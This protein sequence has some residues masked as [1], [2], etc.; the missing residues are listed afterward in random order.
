MKIAARKA[1]KKSRKLTISELISPD[2]TVIKINVSISKNS[3]PDLITK[4]AECILERKSF[5]KELSTD[6]FLSLLDPKETLFFIFFLEVAR[7]FLELGRVPAFDTPV[8]KSLSAKDLNKKIYSISVGIKNVEEI[9]LQAFRLAF[10]AALEVCLWCSKSEFNRENSTNIFINISENVIKPLQK[11]ASAGKSTIPILKVAHTIGMPFIHLGLGVYQLGWGSKSR[12]IDRSSCESDSAIGAKLTQNKIYTAN[13]L[14]KAGMPAPVHGV[15][16]TNLDALIIAQKIGFP[17]VLKPTDRDRG[18]GVTTNVTNE[19]E[20]NVAFNYAQKLSESKQVIVERQVPGVCHRLFIA[21]G[22]LL[23]CVKRSPISVRG[24]GIKTVKELVDEEVSAQSQKPLWSRSEVKSIDELALRA[25][26][27]AGLSVNSIPNK[28]MIVPLRFIEST[29]WGST[30][31]DVTNCVHIENASLA[32]KASEL[33]GLQVCGVDMISK[34][35]S[36]PW[37]KIETI[38]NEVN[39]SPLFGRTEISRSYIPKFFS[40][41]IEGD[42]KIPVEIFD[43]E[44]VAL[45]FQ[46]KKIT[47]GKRCYVI[48]TH[49]TIDDRGQ[50]ITM[51]FE[52]IK[53]KFRALIRR[54]DVDA[55]GIVQPQEIL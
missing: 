10:G 12:R 23:Y 19:D 36:E 49:R 28:D 25:I 53:Q 3:S 11:I 8:V 33:F 4:W 38:I 41:F 44:E 32:I 9:D 13:L 15:A 6:K 40:E 43:T 16:T 55:I 31:E 26:E 2:F 27:N 35:I 54:S 45:E 46:S 39:F 7:K 20:L 14:R 1:L 48:S 18:E 47:S 42:G 37:F 29:E 34:N 51:P 21:N 24:D 17:V 22:K 5:T 52:D 50:E 30:S